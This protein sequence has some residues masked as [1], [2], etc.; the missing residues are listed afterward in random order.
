M[1]RLEQ[2]KSLLAPTTENPLGLEI[3]KA[4]GSY[5]YDVNGKRYLDLVA[6]CICCKC[7]SC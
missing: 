2:F 4:R 6:G 1:S 3:K 5:L 7:R